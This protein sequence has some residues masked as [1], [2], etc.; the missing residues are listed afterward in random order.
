V[1]TDREI[2]RF[3]IPGMPL[4]LPFTWLDIEGGEQFVFMLRR[5]N[6]T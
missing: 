1:L 5:E 6:L 2:K 3:A 4:S